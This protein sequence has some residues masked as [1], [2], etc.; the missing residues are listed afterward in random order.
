MNILSVKKNFLLFTMIISV[1]IIFSNACKKAKPDNDIQSSYDCALS[2][3]IYGTI[4]P[5]ALRIIMHP[6]MKDTTYKNG[7]LNQFSYTSPNSTCAKFYIES[8]HPHVNQDSIFPVVAIIDFGTNGCD[9][10]DG[11]KRKGK[12]R[13]TLTDYF[14]KPGS[15]MTIEFLNYYANDIKVS[16]VITATTIDSTHVD[17]TLTKGTLTN[18]GYIMEFICNHSLELISGFDTPENASDDVYK[19]SGNMSGKNRNGLNYSGSIKS[20]LLHNGSCRFFTDGN[21]E[22]TPENKTPRKIDFGNGTCDQ[23]ITVDVNGNKI[24]I[25]LTEI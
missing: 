1:L 9:D 10:L 22:L 24:N 16:G 14:S 17:F 4:V 8:Y 25:R 18:S 12:I 3:N 6:G 11:I 23:N 20:S 21:I 2:E 13:L 5:Y 19:I 15:V 7:K